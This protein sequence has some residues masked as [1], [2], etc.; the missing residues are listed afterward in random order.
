MK[1]ATLCVANVSIGASWGGTH[2]L[3]APMNVRRHRSA[4]VWEGGD[5]VLRISVGLEARED[6]EAD[7]G[8]LLAVL[9][10]IDENSARK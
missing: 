3:M 6:L 2:S 8:R 9:E 4:T 5:A 10:Q 7:V 1:D